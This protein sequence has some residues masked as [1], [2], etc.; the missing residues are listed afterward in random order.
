MATTQIVQLSDTH[1]IEPGAP[2]EGSYGND[3]GEAF[4]AVAAAMAALPAPDLVVVTGD[5]ADHGRVEQ[6]RIAAEALASLPA[7][8]NAVPGN[9]DND[10]EF[11]VGMGRADVGTS[12]AMVA[13]DWLHLFVDSN[14]GV[15]VEAADGRL[16]D[17]DGGERLH[18][19]GA[20][21]SAESAWV[22]AMC[23]ATTADHVFVWV[24]HPPASTL[25]MQVDEPYTDEWRALLPRCPA[26]R[27]IA[28]GHTH[29][30][31]HYDFEGIPVFV[32]PSLKGN[33]DLVEEVNLPPGFRSFEFGDD[34]SVASQ[35]HLVD[36][37]RWPRT[38]LPR[39][40]L[41]L[42]RAEMTFAEFE[43]HVAAR[44]ARS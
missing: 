26:I 43:A 12:R 23:D 8:V 31:D 21:G 34:G 44:R 11:T 15:M 25:P 30:P 6:Y 37:D 3:I 19:N 1:F 24:H 28:A 38:R 41:A 42:L 13:G 5:V 4:E 16:V 33:F 9:H 40:L 18:R 39:S 2:S 14:R 10:V 29:V 20:L 36:D 27:G 17:P 22:E 7:P 35:L 32:A